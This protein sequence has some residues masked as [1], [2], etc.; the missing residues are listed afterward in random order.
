MF[1]GGISVL[2]FAMTTLLLLQTTT[3]LRRGDRSCVG[4]CGESFVRGVT[5][6]CDFDCTKFKQC[7]RDFRSVC[8]KESSCRGR[9]EEPFRR[10]R[11]CHCDSTCVEFGE[12]CP[13]HAEFCTD[14][15]PEDDYDYS[16]VSPAES[17]SVELA[18]APTQASP[19]EENVEKGQQ[20]DQP[21][22]Q[23]K[24][25]A[26]RTNKEQQAVEP[27]GPIKPD[28][29]TEPVLVYGSV[30]IY[31]KMLVY[32]PFFWNLRLRLVPQRVST[33]WRVPSPIDAMFTRCSC[34]PKTYIFKGDKYWRLDNGVPDMGYPKLISQ[35]FS[36]LQGPI[37]AA[38]PVPGEKRVSEHVF[39]FQGPTVA[40]YLFKK[41]E[42]PASQARIHFQSRRGR[43]VDTRS[44][45]SQLQFGLIHIH[46]K[47][48]PLDYSSVF[49]R[50][51]APAAPTA[52]ISYRHFVV[53]RDS[54]YSLNMRNK[55]VS[56]K[57]EGSIRG[58]LSCP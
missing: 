35:G 3:S 49:T 10:G 20:G 27:G 2:L 52:R 48:F 56:Q 11:R 47:G 17:H 32:G 33:V 25:P 54:Y 19:L 57:P 9:C 51:M 40:K 38:L 1:L 15:T 13:D 36:G 42:C 39:L 29:S 21:P 41:H 44:S 50:P 4:R 46:W 53:V 6:S 31:G 30:L 23:K 37:T 7:C 8:T 58:D 26:G 43:A 24:I 5:C 14:T 45:K 22:P 18:Q 28:K 55:Q 34:Q 16:E 12:C